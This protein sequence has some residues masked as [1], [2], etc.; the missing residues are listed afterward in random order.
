[1]DVLQKGLLGAL[2]HNDFAP[3]S[4]RISFVAKSAKSLVQIPVLPMCRSTCLQEGRLGAVRDYTHAQ[5]A[6]KSEHDVLYL[7]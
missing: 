3:L 7:E 4:R 1:M 5:L 6:V 2:A